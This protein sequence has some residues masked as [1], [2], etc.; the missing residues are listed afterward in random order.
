MGNSI[1]LNFYIKLNIKNAIE[2]FLFTVI[3]EEEGE[4]EDIPEGSIVQ[5]QSVI[6]GAES[7]FHT[8]NELWKSMSSRSHPT[9]RLRHVGNVNMNVGDKNFSANDELW[10]KREMSVFN[11]SQELCEQLRLVLEPTKMSKFK[12][13]YRT[14]KRLNMRKVSF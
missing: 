12:G 9:Q 5:T 4:M 11:F 8:Q 3:G 14:G 1:F 7:T 13:D 10:R 6:R 2:Y